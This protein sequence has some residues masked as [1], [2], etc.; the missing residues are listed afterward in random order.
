[1]N[2]I[3]LSGGIGTRMGGREK[4]F[5]KIGRDTFISRKIRLLKPLFNKIIIVTNNPRLYRGLGVKIVKDREGGVGPLMGLYTGLKASSAKYNFVTT[6]DTP[7]LKTELVRYL[8]KNIDDYD[9]VV[10][11]WHGMIEP[12]CAVYSKKCIPYIK[13]VMDKNRRVNSFYKFSKVKFISEHELKKIDLEGISF[14]NVNTSSD[15]EEALRK[16]TGEKR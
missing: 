2:A 15:Y 5:L 16:E 9:V 11:E 14:F 10:P 6:S 12:L 4:A 8:I 3:V 7:F 13:K 1:M